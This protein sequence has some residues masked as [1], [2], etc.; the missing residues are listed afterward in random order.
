MWY[1]WELNV[2]GGVNISAVSC[3]VLQKS[4]DVCQLWEPQKGLKKVIHINNIFLGL[5]DYHFQIKRVDS[6]LCVWPKKHVGHNIFIKPIMEN[7]A[8]IIKMSRCQIP[9]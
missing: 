9:V 2:R 8:K 1:S 3:W 4:D 7:K 6:I 5:Y